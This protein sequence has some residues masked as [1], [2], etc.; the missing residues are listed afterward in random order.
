MSVLELT[1][2]EAKAIECA[3]RAYEETLLTE[4]MYADMKALRDGLRRREILVHS[5]IERVREGIP[6]LVA[7]D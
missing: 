3:L 2:D 7:T 1:P 6:E 4:I 5:L